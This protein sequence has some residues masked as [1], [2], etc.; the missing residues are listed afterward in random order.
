MRDELYG[1]NIK[2]LIENGEEKPQIDSALYD[3]VVETV[4]DELDEN[5][6][7]INYQELIGAVY[8][9]TGNCHIKWHK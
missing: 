4:F 5:V 2:P 1:K 6:L 8:Y 3:N 7:L 9:L